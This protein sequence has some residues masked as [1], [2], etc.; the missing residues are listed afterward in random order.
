MFP[1]SKKMSDSKLDVVD[2]TETPPLQHPP[3]LYNSTPVRASNH[4]SAAQTSETCR[5]GSSTPVT[6]TEPPIIVGNTVDLPAFLDTL[7]TYIDKI[8]KLKDEK[9]AYIPICC[10]LNTSCQLVTGYNHAVLFTPNPDDPPIGDYLDYRCKPD[11]VA[12]RTSKDTL[13]KVL[14]EQNNPT[15]PAAPSSDLPT[16]A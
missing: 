5:R 12:R 14:E 11:I 2:L 3:P 16:P 10:I 1:R 13:N 6:P 7:S 8:R 15:N 4:G 9:E